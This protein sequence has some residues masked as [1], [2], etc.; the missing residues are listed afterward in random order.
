MVSW[1]EKKDRPLFSFDVRMALAILINRN[2]M[3]FTV[4]IWNW[5]WSFSICHPSVLSED[6]FYKIL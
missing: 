5:Q 3:L 4:K 2:L 6:M 1:E